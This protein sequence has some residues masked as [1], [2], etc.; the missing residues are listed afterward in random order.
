MLRVV[1]K[2][3]NRDFKRSLIF[4]R[5]KPQKEHDPR[6]LIVTNMALNGLY[7]QGTNA[8]DPRGRLE[9]KEVRDKPALNYIR[10][11]LHFSDKI[12]I[13]KFF[14]DIITTVMRRPRVT[15]FTCK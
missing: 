13:E 4:R 9:S 1:Q 2:N 3:L 14:H 7:Y 10:F 12:T 8:I 15:R 5:G 6:T 11:F